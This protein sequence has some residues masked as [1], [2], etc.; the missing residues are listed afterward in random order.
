MNSLNGKTKELIAR[1]IIR[2]RLSQMAVN[3]VYKSGAIKV[4][5]HFAFGYESL[6]VTV[7]FVMKPV[8][9]LV[10]THRNIEYNLARASLVHRKSS[11]LTLRPFLKEYLLEP[12]G[13]RMGRFGSMNLNNPAFGII[14]ASSILGNQFPVA[15]GISLGNQLKKG[16]GIVV[17]T[18]GDGA[19]EEGAFYESLIIAR[20][21]GL[22]VLFLIEDNNWSMHTK[23]SERRTS[24][25]L[26]ELCRSLGMKH[27]YLDGNDPFYYVKKL[28]E[29]RSILVKSRAPV[30]LEVKVATLGDWYNPKTKEHP[31]GK[32]VKYHVG[33]SPSTVISS[34]PIMRNN[35]DDPLFVLRR[36]F[37]EAFLKRLASEEFEAI[38]HEISR[39][40]K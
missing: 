23:I 1:E 22:N 15:C 17:V 19:I 8:D 39:I 13:V 26:E 6:A 29:V 24:I 18:G 5:I 9:K 35:N 20:S 40:R 31:K 16:K 25:N 28:S 21:A 12:D 27:Y 3:E 33:P 34:W 38:S 32:F 14:Y 4:P 11:D 7:S 36:Y 10:L 37:S 2:L 30:C